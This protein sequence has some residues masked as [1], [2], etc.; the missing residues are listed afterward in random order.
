VWSLSLAG[1]RTQTFW[2]INKLELQT[3]L[4]QTECILKFYYQKQ[5]YTENIREMSRHTFILCE[6]TWTHLEAMEPLKEAGN[7]L[8]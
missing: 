5:T 6:C 4:L 8:T 3:E 1:E 2:F 7:V